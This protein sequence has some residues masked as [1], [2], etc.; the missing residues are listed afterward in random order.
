M[1]EKLRLTGG[2][3]ALIGIFGGGAAIT[4][5]SSFDP[6]KAAFKIETTCPAQTSPQIISVSSREVQIN[7]SGENAKSVAPT[8]LQL[9]PEH[10]KADAN[11]L[12][13]DAESS[14]GEAAPSISIGL[15][16]TAAQINIIGAHNLKQASFGATELPIS[17]PSS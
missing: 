17:S 11:T 4:G 7:C 6:H 10:S 16:E 3:L 1:A 15:S 2:A 12:L 9:L 13:I 5:C 8:S 14:S